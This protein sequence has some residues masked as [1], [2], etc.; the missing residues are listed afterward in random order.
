MGQNGAKTKTLSDLRKQIDNIDSQL[1]TLLNKRAAIARETGAVKKHGL[2]FSPSREA[3]VISHVTSLNKGP[4]PDKALEAVF[5]EVVSSCLNLEQQMRISYLGPEGTYSEEAARSRFGAM[6]ELVPCDT[7]DDVVRL[8][9]QGRAE[10]AVVPIENTTEGSVS[11]TLDL[12]LTTPLQVC[13]EALLPIHH[14]L[15]S[16]DDQLDTIDEVVAHPQSLAQCR[17]WLARHI[18]SATLR[19]VASNGA[20]ARAAANEAGRAAIASKRAVRLYG[21]SVLAA[22]V[23]DDPANTTRFLMLGTAP[24]QPT[25]TDKTSLVCSVPNKAGSLEGL[26]AVFAD[27][28]INMTKLE[29]RPAAQGLWDYVFYID[30]DGHQEDQDVARALELLGERATFVRVIG[31][32]PKAIGL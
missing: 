27:Y 20:A 6:A 23:E 30:I 4:L 13:G 7:L 12:L 22:N 5:R 2:K 14:Q 21:L 18:P 15:L 1:V 26:L 11:R 31:S 19:A 3:E 25:G 9:E 16:S 17:E 28:G 8:V 32:Y 29:S 10:V 24:T